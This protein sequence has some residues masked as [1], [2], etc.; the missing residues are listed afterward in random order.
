MILIP[1]SLHFRRNGADLTSEHRFVQLPSNQ[2]KQEI[3]NRV[4]TLHEQGLKQV[5]IAN[6]LGITDQIVNFLKK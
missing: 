4:R 6:E 2:Q 3:I 5:G 1:Q